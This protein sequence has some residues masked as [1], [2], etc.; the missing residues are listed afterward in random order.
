MEIF[1]QKIIIPV[2]SS[3]FVSQS[4][5][6][7]N[8]SRDTRIKMYIIVNKDLKMGVGKI[9]GQVGHGVAKLTRILEK[10]PTQTYKSW[11]KTAEAKIVLKGSEKQM[12]EL[13]EKYKCIQIHDAGK[14]QIP[15]GSMTVIAFPPMEYTEVP[16]E[17]LEMKLL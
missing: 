16:E 12:L 15:E 6:Q 3:E 7:Y 13:S 17:L 10:N 1:I 2:M 8:S 4:K 11:V 14:T 5:E 9:A